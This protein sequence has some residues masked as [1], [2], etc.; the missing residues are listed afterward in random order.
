[1]YLLQFH[2]RKHVKYFTVAIFTNH[3]RPH[4][5]LHLFYYNRENSFSLPFVALVAELVLCK[6]LTSVS[7]R[8]KKLEKNKVT[9]NEY[10]NIFVIRTSRS[11][12]IRC[13]FLYQMKTAHAKVFNFSISRGSK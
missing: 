10:D 13:Y 9:V 12:F 1:M 4:L 8:F 5:R 7:T 3:F 11:V 6:P 2:E